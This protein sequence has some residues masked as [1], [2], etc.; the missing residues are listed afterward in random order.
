M[1]GDS[2]AAQIATFPLVVY[3]FHQFPNYFLLGNLLVLPLLSLIIYC[4]LAYL[5]FARFEIL[6]EPIFYA[7]NYLLELLVLIVRKIE[8]LPYSFTDFLWLST[9]EMALVY[10]LI[11]IVLWSIYFRSYSIFTLSFVIVIALQIN[12][13]YEDEKRLNTSELVFYA[14]DKQT[15]FGIIHQK[16]AFIFMDKDLLKNTASQKFNLHNHKSYLGLTSL[17]KMPLDTNLE[18]ALIWKKKNHL[19]LGHSRLLWINDNFKIKT[20]Q[21]PTDVD[22]CLISDY[23]PIDKLLQTYRPKRIV[24]ARQRNWLVY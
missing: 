18:N 5:L 6:S 11:G 23:F 16:E 13:W 22:Y 10:F 4:G 1:I 24:L 14:I 7:L 2:I 15:A 12:D 20:S 9:F 3:Y 8:S 17:E 19:Q 21:T